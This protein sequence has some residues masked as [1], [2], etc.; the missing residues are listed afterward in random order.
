MKCLAKREMVMKEVSKEFEFVDI[1]HDDL[2]NP[3]L[4]DEDT[5]LFKVF[6]S[7]P[8]DLKLSTT[9]GSIKKKFYLF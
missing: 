5:E 7:S 9:G 6:N 8:A 1:N 4:I 3:I 2:V